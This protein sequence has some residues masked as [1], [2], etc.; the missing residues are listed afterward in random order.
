[1]TAAK[2]SSEAS[3]NR[4]KIFADGNRG[5]YIERIKR[6]LGFVESATALAQRGI[7]KTRPNALHTG[8]EIKMKF[9]PARDGSSLGFLKTVIMPDGRA[10]QISAGNPND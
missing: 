5:D 8:N 4:D 9:L 2:G 1:L 7:G 10:I 6:T 3:T